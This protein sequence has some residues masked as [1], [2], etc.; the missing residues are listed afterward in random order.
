MHLAAAH[1]SLL[2]GAPLTQLPYRGGA[3]LL[4]DLAGDQIDLAFIAL[5]GPVLPLVQARQL[6]VYGV[7][8][9]PA[10]MAPASTTYPR[11][12]DHPGLGGFVHA[13]WLSFAVPTAVP[14]AVALHLNLQL[15]AALQAPSLQAYAAQLGAAAHRPAGLAEAAHFYEG[16]IRSLQALAAAIGLQAQ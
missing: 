3:P 2:T 12:G 11:L 8:A 6:Q 4:T 7:A 9:S 14:E 5:A 15:N 13:A 10:G 1:F 16:E